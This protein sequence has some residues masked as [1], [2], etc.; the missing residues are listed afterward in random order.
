MTEVVLLMLKHCGLIFK[1]WCESE[2][3]YIPEFLRSGFIII[4]NNGHAMI[5]NSH[6]TFDAHSN[7][8]LVVEFQ[9]ELINISGIV[10][11]I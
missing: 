1:Y 10:I 2:Q 6:D 8:R 3:D 9:V 4:T 11:N 5:A 7:D